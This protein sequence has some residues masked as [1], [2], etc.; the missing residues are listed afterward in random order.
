MIRLL[1]LITLMTVALGCRTNETPEQQLHDAEIT[2]NVKSNLAANLGAS[3]VTNISV[4]VTNG[5]VTLAGTV[6]DSAE[7][8]KAIGVAQVAPNVVRVN[9]NLQV[10]SA[11]LP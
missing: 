7:R 5:V 10:M 11:H 1:S 6:H 4:N 8:S 2:A 3:T 9:D